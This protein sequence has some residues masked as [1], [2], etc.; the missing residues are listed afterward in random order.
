MPGGWVE[1]SD[2]DLDVYSDDGT[3]SDEHAFKRLHTLFQQACGA[4]GRV[5][6]PG[7]HLRAW[8]E[9]A[10][11][12]NITHT[13][14]KLPFGPWPKDKALVCHTINLLVAFSVSFD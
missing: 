3:L 4:M 8:F 9:A 2:W 1:F 7:Q 10:G 12:E 13:I 11:F 6:S 5:A 14:I